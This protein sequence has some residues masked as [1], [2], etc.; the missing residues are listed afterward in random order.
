MPS[1]NPTNGQPEVDTFDVRSSVRSIADA[2]RHEKKLVIFTCG[3]MLALVTVYII[4]WPPIFT[5]TAVLMV[6]RDTDPVRDSFYLGWNVFRKDDART[7]IELMTAGPV[8]KEVIEKRKL[9]YDDVYHPFMSHL[10]HLWET[11]YVGR[12][13]RAAKRWLLGSDDDLAPT[14][15]EL[16]LARNIVDMRAGVSIDPVAE[17]NV[18]RLTVKGPS[19]RVAEIANTLVDVYLE[20]RSERHLSEARRSYEILTDQVSQAADELKGIE[21]RRL[22]F[23]RENTLAFDFQKESL[24]VEKLTNLEESIR[25]TQSTIASQ[26]ARLREL[27]A[28]IAREPETRTTATVFES[29]AVREAAR[30]KELELETALVAARNHFREDS[31]EVREILDDIE[32]IQALAAKSEEKIE[33]TSTE[34][35]NGH[36]QEMISQRDEIRQELEGAR[37]GLAVMEANAVELRD[38]LRRVPALQTSLRDMDREYALSQEKY[39]KLLAKQAQAAVS[40]ATAPAAMQSMR[41]VEYAVPP[42]RKSWPRTK[43]LY[44]AALLIGLMLGIAAAVALGYVSGRVRR[45]HIDGGRG[46]LPLYGTLS[47][48][49]EGLPLSVI[50]R[51]ARPER[52]SRPGED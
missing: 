9:G 10:T 5:T 52:T 8:L 45:E 34:S 37:A 1:L 42:A 47:L 15:E 18:G 29:N 27:E 44:P 12:T 40:V 7:E 30:L 24:E 25:A 16:E 51:R 14:E 43:V 11:S 41:V 50:A 32:E 4:V 39:Q 17:S 49:R 48:P 35:L 33:K 31:P 13:Y 36:R 6:E 28:Q 19:R 23:A 26:G 46:T 20:R 2:V 3:L 38:R 21:E 22:E